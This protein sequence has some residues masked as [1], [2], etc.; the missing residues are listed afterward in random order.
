MYITIV[1]FNKKKNQIHSKYIHY[2]IY[3]AVVNLQFFVLISSIASVNY[4]SNAFFG[5]NCWETYK[6]GMK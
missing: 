1:I 2:L 6:V 5:G 4:Y 3:T